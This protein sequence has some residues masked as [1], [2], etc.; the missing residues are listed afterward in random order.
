MLVLTERDGYIRANGAP[1]SLADQHGSSPDELLQRRAIRNLP[2][3][4]HRIEKELACSQRHQEFVA[5]EYSR[6][7]PLIARFS[8]LAALTLTCF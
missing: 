8:Y 3:C 1:R 4:I 2:K 5:A 7:Q 6:F